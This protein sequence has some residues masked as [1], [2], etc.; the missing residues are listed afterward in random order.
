MGGF[1]RQPKR[2][3]SAPRREIGIATDAF[4]SRWRAA[5][6]P[7]LRT[8]ASGQRHRPS[9]PAARRSFDRGQSRHTPGT[10]PVRPSAAPESDQGAGA[11]GRARGAGR[12]SA[13]R[14]AHSGALDRPEPSG[15]LK[16]KSDPAARAPI[17]TSAPYWLR[18]TQASALLQPGRAGCRRGRDARWGDRHVLHGVGSVASVGP[19][20]RGSPTRLGRSPLQAQALC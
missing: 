6:R 1:F 12:R 2:R 16:V 8:L 5:R 7:A 17:R 15:S 14:G 13:I 9:A 11:P 4:T 10:W 20:D 3:A 18:P 19:K